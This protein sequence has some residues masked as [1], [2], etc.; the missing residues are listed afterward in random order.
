MKEKLAAGVF[1]FLLW[2]VGRGGAS[3]NNWAFKEHLKKET[4]Q[5]KR[6]MLVSS[7]FQILGAITEKALLST[8]EKLERG[9]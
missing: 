6:R 4:G 9:K 5:D 2:A 3:E 1:C 7:P 8:R